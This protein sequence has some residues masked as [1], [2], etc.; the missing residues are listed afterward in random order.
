MKVTLTVRRA[1]SNLTFVIQVPLRNSDRASRFENQIILFLH[2]VGHEPIC[3]AAWNN[4]IVFGPVAK[5]TKNRFECATAFKDKNDLIGAAILVIL[6]VTVSF[7]RERP[8]SHHVLIKENGNTTAI[9]IATPGNGRRFE[10]M[11]A[12]RT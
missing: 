9:E 3:N 10:M 5:L 6:E 12:K 11:M 8:I 2:F 4:D 1:H 7:F